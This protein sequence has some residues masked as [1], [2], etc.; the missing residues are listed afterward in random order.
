MP[1]IQLSP[2]QRK[3]HETTQL[4]TAKAQEEL[5]Q[6]HERIGSLKAQSDAISK[7]ARA[8]GTDML[9][10]I[11][12]AHGVEIPPHTQ[13][14]TEGDDMFFVWNDEEKKPSATVN[15]RSAAKEKRAEKAQAKADAKKKA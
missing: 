13:I 12:D 3:L 2:I 15:R 1:K 14:L 4:V 9:E 5:T 10:L 6:I 11:G 7:A 8:N